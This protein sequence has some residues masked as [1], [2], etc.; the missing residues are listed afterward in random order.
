[1]FLSHK[2]KIIKISLSQIQ[3]N[4][5]FLQNLR[6]YLLTQ[7]IKALKELDWIKII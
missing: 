7:Q 5:P 4:K 2:N 3:N 6:V 1:M